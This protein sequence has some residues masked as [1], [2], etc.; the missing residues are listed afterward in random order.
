[1]ITNSSYALGLAIFESVFVTCLRGKTFAECL[2]VASWKEELKDSS[3][4]DGYFH[5]YFESSER[6]RSIVDLSGQEPLR[7]LLSSFL[8]D[9]KLSLLFISELLTVVSTGVDLLFTV[10]P[11]FLCNRF[12]RDISLHVAGCE[13]FS[14]ALYL[15]EEL[16][17]A[18]LL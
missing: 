16:G 1:M 15:M 9:V 6:V 12:N 13:T 8:V 10:P 14:S 7:A 5:E 17:L 2:G 4:L 18:S 3:P 11:D